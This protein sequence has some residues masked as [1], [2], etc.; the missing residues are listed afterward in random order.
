VKPIFVNVRP[1]ASAAF[2]TQEAGYHLREQEPGGFADQYYATCRFRAIRTGRRDG[3]N[4]VVGGGGDFEVDSRKHSTA[5]R[6]F[7]DI[8]GYWLERRTRPYG[9]LLEVKM[10]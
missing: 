10:G 1:V 3:L 5:A 4:V 8:N 2:T 6:K 7:G 9:G